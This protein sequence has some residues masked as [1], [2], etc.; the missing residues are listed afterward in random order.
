MSSVDVLIPTYNPDPRFLKEALE[1]LQAQTFTNWKAFIHEDPSDG[2]TASIVKPF[3][4]DERITFKKSPE[5]LGI[6]GNW[7][8]CFNATS[9]PIIAYLFQD[10][11]WTPDYLETAVNIMNDNTGVGLVAMGHEYKFE[12]TSGS[13]R[14]F[15]RLLRIKKKRFPSGIIDGDKFLKKWLRRSFW[16]NL[17]GEPDF[18]VM[19]RGEMELAG[20]PAEARSAQ[21]GPFHPTMKQLLD[22]EYWVRMLEITDLYNE[23]KN[24]GQF[25]VHGGA[26]TAQNRVDGRGIF[27]RLEIISRFI[28]KGSVLTRVTAIFAFVIQIL[29]MVFHAFKHPLLALK[30][31]KKIL[32]IKH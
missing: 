21:A 4:S 3:L 11:L 10:D 26:A 8:A 6:G 15:K 16:P 29:R 30:L 13:K 18:V 20:L 28:K 22:T 31:F 1:S 32:P 5:R 12:D 24:L 19:S 27:D 7:N 9:A 17:V 14:C 25:R 23:T 2:D